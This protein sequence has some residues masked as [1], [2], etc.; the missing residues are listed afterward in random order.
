MFI[1][2]LRAVVTY[3]S[4]RG[5]YC[6]SDISNLHCLLTSL[7]LNTLFQCQDTFICVPFCYPFWVVTVLL[8]AVCQNHIYSKFFNKWTSTYI[9]CIPH[10]QVYHKITHW[11]QRLP[12]S[13]EIIFMPIF[14][15]IPTYLVS[16]EHLESTRIQ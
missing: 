6:S 8:L 11:W 3:L 12:C 1:K 15:H 4:R 14:I 16:L 10:C 7:D 2:W 5:E 9:V 13:S